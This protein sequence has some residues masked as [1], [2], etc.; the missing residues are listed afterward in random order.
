M[1]IHSA[2]IIFGKGDKH[3]K[4][5][6]AIEKEDLIESCVINGGEIGKEANTDVLF[7]SCYIENC[8]YTIKNLEGQL[9][10]CALIVR[11][12]IRNCTLPHCYYSGCRFK[13]EGE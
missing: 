10:V 2:C 11:C 1:Q 4:G 6:L 12:T 13:S 9:P 3:P 8:E 7:E 5:G